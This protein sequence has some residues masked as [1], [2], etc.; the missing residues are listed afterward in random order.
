MYTLA[1]AL[2]FGL[3][4]AFLVTYF[5]CM[6]NLTVKSHYVMS[7]ERVKFVNL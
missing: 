6:L 3:S 7:I 5:L 1:A 4:P 2:G